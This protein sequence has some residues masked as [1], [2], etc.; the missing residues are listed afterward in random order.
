VVV[1]TSLLVVLVTTA[2]AAARSGPSITRLVADAAAASDG[3]RAP[4]SLLEAAVGAG[5]RGGARVRGGPMPSAG[6][7]GGQPSA[8]AQLAAA[9]SINASA[10]DQRLKNETEFVPPS[11]R[12]ILMTEYQVA[13]RRSRVFLVGPLNPSSSSF[14]LCC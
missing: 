7:S 5:T 1:A 2:A 3:E 4:A 10:E 12:D 14:V 13:L 8:E 6:T 11:I 9:M